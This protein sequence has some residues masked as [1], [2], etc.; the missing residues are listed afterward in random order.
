MNGN[1]DFKILISCAFWT[2]G[3]PN[4]TRER[5]VHYTW[6]RMK[7]L[8][9]FLKENNLNCETKIY[10]F[11]PT[12]IVSDS[13]HIPYKLGEYKKAQ[14]VNII[15]NDN[16]NFDFVMMF[17]SDCFFIESDYDKILKTLK[18]LN[19]NDVV[20]FDCAKLDEGSISSIIENNYLDVEN[21]DWWFAFSGEKKNGPL[22]AGIRGGL[23]GV[24][25]ADLKLLNNIGM[26]DEKYRGWGEEDQEIINRI[27]S[28]P[29]HCHIS[30]R[31]FFPFHLPHFVDLENL[32]YTKRF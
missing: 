19:Y 17:D 12:K 22:F 21:T 24:Y 2:D 16:K 15:L 3:K 20:S 5:N 28:Y 29:S 14:K 6:S 23:G 10:D 4:S 32:E 7:H 18:S 13:V 1:N 30:I 27:Y 11:S 26:F 25:I 31:D 9:E 8:S